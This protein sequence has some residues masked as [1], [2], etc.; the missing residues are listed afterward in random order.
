MHF[1][2]LAEELCDPDIFCLLFNE[3]Y[4]LER[5][6]LMYCFSTPSTFLGFKFVIV[7]ITLQRDVVIFETLIHFHLNIKMV[8][9]NSLFRVS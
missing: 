5:T 6:V 2:I 7:E 8:Y 4:E 3:Y 9:D 1:K